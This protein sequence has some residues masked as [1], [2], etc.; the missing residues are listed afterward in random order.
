M[1]K[2]AYSPLH[3]SKSDHLITPE[4]RQL[5][6]EKRRARNPWQHSHY[7][8]DRHNYNSLSNEL[9]SVLKTH[10]KELYKSHLA[11]LFPNNGT[12]WKKIKSLLQHKETLPSLLRDDNSLAVDDQDK[13]DLLASHLVDSFK[14]HSSL[15]SQNHIDLV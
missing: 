14:P 11:S 15:P 2:N 3:G 7:P 4:I 13:A 5:I 8:E 6:T 1:Q 10:K 12:L 9:K